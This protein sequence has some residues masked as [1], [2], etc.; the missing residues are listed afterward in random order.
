MIRFLHISDIHSTNI[1]GNDDDYAQMKC[2]FLENIAEC[3][4]YK[5]TIDYILI[6]GDIAFSGMVRG[7]SR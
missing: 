3:S 5:G 7:C 1:S 2:K 6:C 4:N